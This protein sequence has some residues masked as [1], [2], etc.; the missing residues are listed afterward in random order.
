MGMSSFVSLNLNS[1]FLDKDSH[2]IWE[3]EALYS[4]ENVK[5]GINNTHFLTKIQLRLSYLLFPI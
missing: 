5:V 1:L 3:K 2:R 4:I